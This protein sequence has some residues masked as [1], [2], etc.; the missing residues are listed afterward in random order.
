MH[1]FDLQK[2]LPTLICIGSDTSTSSAAAAGARATVEPC[3]ILSPPTTTRVV[4]G[5]WAVGLG[6]ASD[7]KLAGLWA[8]AHRY[9]AL[10]FFKTVTL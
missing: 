7:T 8:S 10:L 3:S 5:G 2:A 1:A 9:A 4:T 6:W